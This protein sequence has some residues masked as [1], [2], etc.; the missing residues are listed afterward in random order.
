MYIEFSSNLMEEHCGIF[1][2]IGSNSIKNTIDGLG[3]L[4]HRGYE[5]SGIAYFDNNKITIHKNFGLVEDVYR[6][7]KIGSNPAICVGHVRYSTRKEKDVDTLISDVQPFEGKLDDGTTFALAHNGNIPMINQISQKFGLQTYSSDSYTV[8]K[9]IEIMYAKYQNIDSVMTW[10]INMVPTAY[11]L[12]ILINGC[13]YVLRDRYG[14]RPLIIGKKDYN[15]CIASETVALPPNFEVVKRV[16]PGEVIRVDCLGRLKSVYVRPHTNVPTFCSFEYIYFMHFE[17]YINSKGD[18]V[19]DLRYRMGYKLGEKCK[20]IEDN[21]VVVPVPNSSIPMAQ[22]YAASTGIT[23]C[24][25]LIKNKNI[26]RTF[27]IGDKEKRAQVCKKKF[28]YQK[29]QIVDKNIILIDDSV[30]RGTTMSTIVQ[31]LREYG[32]NKVYVVVMS[33]PV[34]SPC[35]FG[36]DMS[37][38]EELLAHDRTNEEIC[39]K[40]YADTVTYYKL[41]DMVDVFKEFSYDSGSNSGNVCTSCFTG[42]YDKLLDW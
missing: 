14:V 41:E 7:F 25:A 31:T 37:T 3:K 19:R 39:E 2:Y 17:S 28:I 15:M 40:L 27:I 33:P 36:I 32:A 42:N 9:L 18:T 13:V 12:L 4:Q 24:Q 23:Y 6:D 16:E 22:G 29:D 8:V 5:G 34:T 20:H 35:Y 1:G 26:N 10:I 21:S 30:V 38:K 11:C